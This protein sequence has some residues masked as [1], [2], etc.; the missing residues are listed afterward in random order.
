LLVRLSVIASIAV[1]CSG[2]GPDVTLECVAGV[3]TLNDVGAEDPSAFCAACFEALECSGAGEGSPDCPT[4]ITGSCSADVA[5]REY[6]CEGDCIAC[7]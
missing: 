4:G 3:P 2:C 5:E 6:C 1:L 7:P